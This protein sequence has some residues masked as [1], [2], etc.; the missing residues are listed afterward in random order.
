MKKLDKR[1]ELASK[2]LKVG[3]NRITFDSLKLAEIKEAITKQDIKDLYAEGI[4]SIKPKSGRLTKKKRKTKKKA[5]KIKKKVNIRKQKYV[6]H[7]RKLRKYIKEL[8]KQEKLSKEEY[9]E[10]RKKIR[11]KAFRSKSQ[12]KESMG[13]GGKSQ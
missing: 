11:A 3:K 7:T 8:I 12:L 5:G 6:K 13:T 9:G 2:V 10:L 1:K 4:I